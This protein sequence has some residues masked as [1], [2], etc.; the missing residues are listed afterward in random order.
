MF[1]VTENGVE[2]HYG[3]EG[4]AFPDPAIDLLTQRVLVLMV[5]ILERRSAKRALEWR[6][7]RPDQADIVG[8]GQLNDLPITGDH[9]IEGRAH[10]IGREICAG[11]GNVVDADQKDPR[12]HTWLREHIAL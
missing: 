3:I 9:L 12:L 11:S 10:L 8:A 1:G 5:V 2:I 4:T 7:C 6:Q